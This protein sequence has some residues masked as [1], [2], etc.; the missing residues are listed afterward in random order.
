VHRNDIDGVPPRLAQ[1]LA[2]LP[3]ARQPGPP[4]PGVEPPTPQLGIDM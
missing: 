3:H 2:W 1:G 4:R